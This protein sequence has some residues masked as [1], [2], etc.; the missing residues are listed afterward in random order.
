MGTLTTVLVG[1]NDT[2]RNTMSGG[3]WALWQHSDQLAKLRA[4]RSLI[5]SFVQESLR[6][7][8]PSMNMRRTAT[9]DYVFHGKTIRK[10]DKVVL[11][12]PSANR[13]GDAID[14]PDE[15][16]VDRRKPNQHLSFG[17]GIHRCLGARLAE[18]QLGILWEEFL[19]RDIRFEVMKEPEYAYSA[20]FRSIKR[21]PVRFMA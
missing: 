18:M 2:T 6:W 17:H 12:Y 1:G 20:T 16:L 4:D 11:W 14:C 8:T 9:A 21:L 5:P 10:G 7:Q 15:F 13:D 19:D 3:L